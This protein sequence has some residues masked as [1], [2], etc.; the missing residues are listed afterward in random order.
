LKLECNYNE[1]ESEGFNMSQT[2]I[3]TFDNYTKYKFALEEF[4]DIEH[5]EA[6]E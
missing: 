3:S 6:I 1:F 5:C 2:I 4:Q